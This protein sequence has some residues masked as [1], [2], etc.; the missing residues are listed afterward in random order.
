LGRALVIT[1]VAL[2]LVMIIG[3]GLLVRTL[4]NLETLDQGFSSR[5]VLL[6]GFNP[7]KAGYKDERAARLYQE[8]LERIP[9][10]PGVRSE[11]LSFLTPI[12]GG[13]WDNVARFVEGYS[14]HPSEDMDTYINAVGPRFFETLGTPVLLGR[15]F[16]PED[17]SDSTPVALINQ[18]MARRFFANRNPLGKHFRL[19]DWSGKREYEIIGVA[20]DAKYLSLRENVPPTAYIYIP[21]LQQVPA[22]VTFEVSSAVPPISLVP[23]VRSLLQSV[24]SR[25]AATEV[26]TLAEQVDQSLYQ[27]KMISALSSFFGVLALVLVCIGLYGVL[28]YA[29]ARRTNEIG[30]R[31]ALGAERPVILQMVLRE[32]LLLAAIGVLIGLPCAWAATRS[33]ASMLYGL[34]TTDPPTILAA[35]LLMAAV[36][37]FA[38]YLPARR[39]TKVDPMVALRYE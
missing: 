11:S 19:G 14:P 17:Q 28:S 26:K 5:G 6:F 13:G 10:M 35:T 16:G 12:S 33:I 9:Q 24:D 29:V 31:M 7:T 4:H 36:A 2:S 22:G 23:Q 32:A 38:G 1:Q 30:I 20:G 15:D 3:A 34:K 18:T 39:A 27:E 25:L 37:L 8:V 21:Q